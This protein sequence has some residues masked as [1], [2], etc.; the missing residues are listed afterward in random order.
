MGKIPFVR[1]SYT[2]MGLLM[3]WRDN[4]KFIFLLY[5]MMCCCLIP[6]HLLNAQDNIP[7]GT[8]RTHLSFASVLHVTSGGG[9]VFA[10]S[11]NGILRYEVASGETTVY[12]TLNA[13]S[14]SNISAL[15]YDEARQQLL[16]GYQDGNI[17][18]IQETKTINF[19]RLVNPRDI[20]VSPSINDIMVHETFAYFS[21]AYGVVAFDL[22]RN[23]VRETWRNLGATGQL[24]NIHQSVVKGDSIYLATGKGVLVG[25]LTDNLLDFNQWT[26]YDLGDLNT[27]VRTITVFNN[28]VYIAINTKGVYQFE[29]S[30]W[31]SENLLTS[32]AS[33]RFLQGESGILLIGGDNKLWEVSSSTNEITDPLITNVQQ[34]IRVQGKYWIADG[35]TGLLTDQGGS[36][37]QISS[38]GP[39]FSKAIGITFVQGSVYV[40]HGGYTDNFL[41]GDSV[42]K[43]SRFAQGLWTTYATST[44]FAT[45]V[46]QGAGQ[47]IYIGSFGD[48]L[49]KIEMDGTSTIFNSTNSPLENV[50]ANSPFTYVPALLSSEAGLWVT[51]FAA[52]KPLHLLKP[53]GTWQSFSYSEFAGRYPFKIQK[54]FSDNLW[55]LL[56]PTGGGGILI[57]KRDGSLNRY[58]TE[59]PGS[60][61][62]PSDEVLCLHV[63]ENGHMWIGTAKGVVYYTFPGEEGIKPIVDGRFL[64]SEERVTAIKV[65][66]GNRKWIGTERGL[67]LFNES[68]EEVIYN[69]TTENSPLL[70]NVIIEIEIDDSSGEVFISTDKGL[71]SF[72][73]DATESIISSNS[74][75]VFPNPVTRQFSGL[76]GITNLYSD[77]IVKITSLSGQLINELRANGGTA[78]WNLTDY[79][80]KRVGTGMYLII[81]SS[82]DGSESIAGKIVV[83]D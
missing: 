30:T 10:A 17:D 13:L 70:S 21:T 37:Q 69:F 77:S 22:Q 32:V 6:A 49:E 82:P 62:L 39:A 31:V 8:W 55:L 50:V 36:W 35:R 78:S 45:D 56:A 24:L 12:S 48:G 4:R 27:V 9:Y 58:L 3:L 7:L 81:A 2:S 63:D 42:K 47:S 80:G 11:T 59:Q 83:I 64:L 18:L 67:W 61:A 60:G 53:D 65:D 33:F 14:G 16:V 52:S 72:R 1:S 26:R 25:K 44:R 5:A 15:C 20:T 43:I 54:D 41:P 19:S 68:G 71:I 74:A 46:E 79:N 76:V 23:E 40:A 34:A 51:N 38:N 57:V 75:K 29:G 66:A 73:A 28:N